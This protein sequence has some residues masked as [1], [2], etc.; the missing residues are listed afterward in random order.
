MNYKPF[1]FV[2]SDNKT[3]TMEELERLKAGLDSSHT[4]LLKAN[5]EGL[6]CSF[7]KYGLVQDNFLVKDEDLAQALKQAG[8][9]GVVEGY[10]FDKLRNNYGWFSLKVKSKKLLKELK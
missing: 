9:N 10:S 8:I 4:M 2:Y 1:G 7:I 5:D 3:T 6:N